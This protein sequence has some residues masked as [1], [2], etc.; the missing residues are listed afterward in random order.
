M[1]QYSSFNL[2]L[3]LVVEEGVFNHVDETVYKYVPE[4]KGKKTILVSENF[5]MNL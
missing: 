1:S 5:L 2:P 4:I 3:C